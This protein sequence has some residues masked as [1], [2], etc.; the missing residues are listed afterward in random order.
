MRLRNILKEIKKHTW[1]SEEAPGVP[2]FCIWIRE[3]IRQS[4][5]WHPKL[6]T[7]ALMFF[8]KDFIYEETPEDQKIKIWN[9]VLK[10]YLA[11]PSSQKRQYRIWQS[12]V[13]NLKAE[14]N[15]FLARHKTMTE[16]EVANS[17]THFVGFVQDHWAMTWVQ[18]S[19][20]IFSS[21]R[22]LKL[23]KKEVPPSWKDKIIDIALTLSA[24]LKLSFMEEEKIEL[25]GLEIK[26]YECLRKTRALKEV[27][28]PLEQKI[29]ALAQKYIWFSSNYKEGKSLSALYLWKQMYDQ[30]RQKSRQEILKK[31]SSL[32]TKVVRLRKKKIKLLRSL[33]LSKRLL[34]SLKLL[35]FWANWIDERKKVALMANWYLERYAQEIAKRLRCN[36]WEVK[37]MT[38]EEIQSAL[39][40]K[41]L[42][43]R[44]VL[45]SRRKFSVFVETKQDRRICENIFVGKEAQ[46]LW[47]ALFSLEKTKE[48]RGQV[49]SAPVK[50]LEGKAQVVL[51]VSKQRFEAGNILVTTM[52]RPEF[53]PL[54]HQAKAIITD[55]GGLIC[56]AAIISRELG[57]PCLIG[58]KIATKVLHNGELVKI[59]LVK[60]TVK[61]K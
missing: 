43:S 19:A 8:K 49:A 53:M 55:E 5:F 45:R 4:K 33:N 40:Y 57:I 35:E 9:Y 61:V 42:I 6:P 17:F 24:P 32:K 14:G 46:R 22:L 50:S 21:Y 23:L 26:W 12:F 25:L 56:H 16:T 41:K 31:L 7:I 30:C 2:M 37:Y 3:F 29:K 36:V 59:D 38:L 15:L 60:G 10:K 52:T 11:D 18:E 27:P 47:E 20:D 51:D 39:L 13:K 1:W 44:K 58:T 54:L 28:L 48:I 34:A